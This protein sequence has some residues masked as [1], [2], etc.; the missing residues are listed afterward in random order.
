MS[1]KH[2]NLIRTKMSCSIV[3]GD[4]K[5]IYADYHTT[6]AHEE[7]LRKANEQWIML[8]DR[9]HTILADTDGGCD[10]TE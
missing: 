3:A 2:Y 1:Q 6:T 8:E 7:L 4:D 10:R 5:Y 9:E